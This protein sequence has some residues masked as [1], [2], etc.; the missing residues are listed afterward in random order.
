[1]HFKKPTSDWYVGGPSYE[2]TYGSAYLKLSSAE[3]AT[4]TDVYTNMWPYT[5]P[6]GLP[7]DYNG[8]GKV[9]IND[10]NMTINMMLGKLPYKAICD[11]NN[12]GKIDI[13]DVNLII[14]KMLGK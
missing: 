6:V 13:T 4:R 8:D 14:N 11:I 12:D 2:R 10:V 3:A 7:G 9:D 1:M 5:P